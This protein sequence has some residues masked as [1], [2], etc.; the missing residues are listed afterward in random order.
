MG[1][2]NVGAI[3]HKTPF[4][5]HNGFASKFIWNARPCNSD[6]NDGYA[7]ILFVFYWL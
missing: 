5:A 1:E 2:D 6:P 4:L 3:I 7:Y